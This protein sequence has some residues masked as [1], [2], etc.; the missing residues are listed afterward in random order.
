M[1]PLLLSR[2]P[3]E[4][5]VNHCKTVTVN[6][7]THHHFPFFIF[8]CVKENAQVYKA[9]SLIFRFSLFLQLFPRIPFLF[10]LSLV[11]RRLKVTREGV[12]EWTG[13]R[14]PWFPLPVDIQRWVRLN[15]H[16]GE[17]S[18]ETTARKSVPGFAFLSPGTEG[19]LSLEKRVRTYI[20]STRFLPT[21]K[22]RDPCPF[23]SPT[24]GDGWAHTFSLP[25]LRKWQ[26]GINIVPW[27]LWTPFGGGGK[28]YPTGLWLSVLGLNNWEGAG[29]GKSGE[30]VC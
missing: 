20:P 22:G 19:E 16:K 8:M 21:G 23:H 7:R 4:M 15:I 12:S 27:W 13:P 30:S 5:C 28:P 24:G 10:K 14:S 25:R 26:M 18:G 2:E 11:W 9:F 1:W 29:R 3:K 17:H 6:I